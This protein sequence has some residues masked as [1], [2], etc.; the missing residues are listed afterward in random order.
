MKK[1]LIKRLSKITPEEQ[2]ILDGNKDIDR[3]IYYHSKQNEIDAALLLKQGRL[4]DIRPNTRFVHFPEHTHNFVEFVYMVQGHTTH[5]IDGNKVELKSGDLLFMNQH[6]KQEIEPAGKDDI[7]VNFI[8]LPA[9]FDEVLKR[10][11]DTKSTLCDFLIGCLTSKGIGGNYLYFDVSD[12]LPVQNLMENLI[13][14][15]LDSPEKNRQ[16]SQQTMAL[17]FLHL[18]NQTE[19]LHMADDSYDK[20]MMLTLLDYINTDYRTA[21]FSSFC[22]KNHIDIYT[23]GRIIKKNTGKNFTRL[24]SE[25]RMDMATWFLKNTALPVTEISLSVGYENTSYFY[26][27]FEKTYG[28][29]PKAVRLGQ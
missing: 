11:G 16:I 22:E 1:K 29:S 15:M 13:I 6:A 2:K 25:K 19:H 3:S 10:I 8:I 12:V 5:Y 20:K 7:A 9:F 28:K 27:L 17:L 18:M 24:L 26:R 23:M 4:I 21:S 14:L